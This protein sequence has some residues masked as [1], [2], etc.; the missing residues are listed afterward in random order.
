MAWNFNLAQTFGCTSCVV[1]GS[2]TPL[3][4]APSK[5]M[6]SWDDCACEADHEEVD[7]N[8]ADK[9]IG[10]VSIPP[11]EHG[12]CT[13]LLSFCFDADPCKWEYN[14]VYKSTNAAANIT[15]FWNGVPR[16]RSVGSLD[17]GPLSMQL[18]CGQS[19]AVSLTSQSNLCLE[20]L[21]A[22]WQCPAAG[23]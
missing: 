19:S 17:V 20:A 3:S 16:V 18:D 11:L 6:T 8:C 9:L 15:L 22:C 1:L 13:D 5:V 23:D 21:F 4:S 14:L 12:T 10:D 2:L 7:W